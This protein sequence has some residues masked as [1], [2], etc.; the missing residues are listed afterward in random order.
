MLTRPV[1][2]PVIGGIVGVDVFVGVSLEASSVA[3]TT[4]VPFAIGLAASV[5]AMAVWICSSIVSCGVDGPHAVTI[6]T[7]TRDKTKWESFILH[8]PRIC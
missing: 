1:I 7:I 4:V 6:V 5:S 3:G 8:L 2:G